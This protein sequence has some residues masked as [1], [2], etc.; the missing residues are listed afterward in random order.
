MVRPGSLR[1]SWGP[2]CVWL[3][4]SVMTTSSCHH[5][6]FDQKQN[7][8]CRILS[9]H[10]TSVLHLVSDLSSPPCAAPAL[11]HRREKC[12]SITTRYDQISLVT[13]PLTTSSNEKNASCQRNIGSCTPVGK[14]CCALLKKMVA[15]HI[16]PLWYDL[17]SFACWTCFLHRQTHKFHQIFAPHSVSFCPLV[18]HHL[19]HLF[20]CYGIPSFRHSE[21]SCCW[22]HHVTSHAKYTKLLVWNSIYGE[23]TGLS[24]TTRTSQMP[25]KLTFEG[26]HLHHLRALGV[27]SQLLGKKLK[28]VHC[29]S[30]LSCLAEIPFRKQVAHPRWIQAESIRNAQ[31]RQLHYGW[32]KTFW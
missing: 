1:F 16:S 2:S 15:Q 23:S 8:T 29:K 14:K 26:F 5:G 27:A 10:E 6:W 7:G 9:A 18:N 19:P 20:D 11:S 3:A 21:R 12:C 13:L 32:W 25:W 24:A 30:C 4:F 22:L 17:Q 28:P 31:Y